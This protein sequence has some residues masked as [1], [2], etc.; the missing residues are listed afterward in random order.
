[1]FGLFLSAA[2]AWAIRSTIHLT[3]ST[4]QGTPGQ[5]V[6]GRDM[7]LNIPFKADWAAI[8]KQKQDLI[9]ISCILPSLAI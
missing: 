5:L 2:A 6:F 7:L 9:G 8:R 3:T 1:L 4:L